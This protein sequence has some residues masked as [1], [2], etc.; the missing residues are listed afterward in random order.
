MSE[1]VRTWWLPP[2]KAGEPIEDR[3]VSFLE[4]FFDLVFVVLIARLSQHLSADPGRQEIARTGLLL[5]PVWSAWINGTFYHDLHATNDI[6]IRVFTFAQMVTIAGMAVYVDTATGAGGAGFAVSYA[7]NHLVLAGMWYRTG[8]H[9]PGHRP[10]SVPFTLVYMASAALFVASVA[11]APPGRF[12]MW[13][14]GLL[15]EI[16]LLTSVGRLVPDPAGLRTRGLSQAV[17][18][19]F[20]LLVMIVLGGVV[21]GAIDGVSF[22]AHIEAEVLFTGFEAVVVACGLWW[23]YFDFV[24]RLRPIPARSALWAN[25]HFFVVAGMA[26]V[27]AAILNTVAHADEDFP[28]RVHWLLAGSL[29]LTFLA[30]AGLI[31]VLEIRRVF[32]RAYRRGMWILV[33]MAA[34]SLGTGPLPIG[35]SRSLAIAWALLAVPIGY[36]IGTWVQL[37]QRGV[38]PEDPTRI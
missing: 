20:G 38:W 23:I 26:G 25:L 17:V 18:E 15:A 29:S 6:S 27:G 32:P 37:K 22:N 10:A 8:Y 31:A 4:L 9:D 33:A 1:G 24:A 36:G 34:V 28:P 30:I 2:R 11:V 12:V 5:V 16:V 19:R 21:V 14:A 13:G 35:Q 7:L 3:A